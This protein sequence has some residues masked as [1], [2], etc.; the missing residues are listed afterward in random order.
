MR[1]F[2]PIVL[3]L[4]AR[5]IHDPSIVDAFQDCPAH[6]LLYKPLS[7]REQA[8][9]P[10]RDSEGNMIKKAFQD[11]TLSDTRQR[12]RE[13]LVEALAKILP[14][15]PQIQAQVFSFLYEIGILD[16]NL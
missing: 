16:F 1:F 3:D 4:V 11:L 13:I 15:A 14:S 12:H 8:L 5:W 7:I 6:G 2:R 9:S 10:K